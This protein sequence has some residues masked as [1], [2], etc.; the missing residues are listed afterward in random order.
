MNKQELVQI[1]SQ[2]MQ[3][4]KEE[5]L[6]FVNTLQDIITDELKQDGMLMLQGFGTFSPWYQAT[7]MARNPKTGEPCAVPSRTSVKFKPGKHLL[8]HLNGLDKSE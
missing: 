5:A 7:R 1:I 4:T 3:V 6:R 2:K 8:E